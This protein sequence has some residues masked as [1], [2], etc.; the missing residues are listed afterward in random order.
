[1]KG[2]AAAVAVAAAGLALSGVARAESCAYEPLT[3]ALSASVTP[4]GSAVLVV[5]GGG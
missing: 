2:L 1:V 5:V 3:R 4:G